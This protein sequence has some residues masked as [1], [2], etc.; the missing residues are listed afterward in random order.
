MARRVPFSPEDRGT[1]VVEVLVLGVGLLVPLVYAAI[2]IAQVQ[3]A[4]YAATSAAREAARAYSLAATTAEGDRSA[5]A[6][7]ALLLSDAGIAPVAPVV[8]CTGGC[9]QPGSRVDVSVA[10]P[11]TLPLVPGGPTLTVTG[12]ASMPVDRYR[13]AP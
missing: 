7:S 9:L 3:A 6:A 13:E 12:E 4:A 5:R 8:R 10:V 1:A 2:S 11:V